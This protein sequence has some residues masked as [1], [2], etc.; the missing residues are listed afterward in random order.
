[1]ESFGS[2]LSCKQYH[3]V[4]SDD[5]LRIDKEP[6]I[7]EVASDL[8]EYEITCSFTVN[9]GCVINLNSVRNEPTN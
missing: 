3:S 7:E 4:H 2:C 5:C 6:A 8:T 9:F 1:M